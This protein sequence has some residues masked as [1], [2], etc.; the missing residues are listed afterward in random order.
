M[1]RRASER[2]VEEL[3]QREPAIRK[4]MTV[5]E[6]LNQNEDARKLY[7]MR[8]KAQRDEANML[9]GAREEAMAAGRA[10]GRAEGIAQGKADAKAEVTRNM[11]RAGMSLAQIAA[12]TGCTEQE[13]EELK[14]NDE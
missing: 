13:I 6:F 5:L 10:E 2:T 4:A 7:E 14:K 11:L 9:E 3:A 12:F 1:N 8:L